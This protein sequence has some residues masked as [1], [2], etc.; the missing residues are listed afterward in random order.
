MSNRCLYNDLKDKKPANILS[1]LD[2]ISYET[3]HGFLQGVSPANVVSED[4]TKFWVSTANVEK[5]DFYINFKDRYKW[6][7]ILSGITI[8]WK[9]YPQEFYVLC[10]SPEYGVWY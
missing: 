10:H 2:F 6:S 3:W 1:Q 4:R 9:Y 7:R 8:V 5:V